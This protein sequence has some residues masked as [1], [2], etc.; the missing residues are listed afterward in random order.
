MKSGRFWLA[1]LVAGV[2]MNIVDFVVHGLWLG[3]TYMMQHTTLFRQ[4][5]NVAWWI[6]GDFIWVFVFAWIF[7]KVSGSFGSTVKDGI[8]AGFYLGV[9]ANFPLA[10]YMHLMFN[11]FP[12]SL[13]WISLI[14]GIVWYMI[15]GAIFAAVLKPKVA[16]A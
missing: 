7:S 11:D 12:Y 4:D 5:V 6:V 2:V 13:S 16:A 15:V 3:P 10:L 8:T 9:F 14:Y 1:V